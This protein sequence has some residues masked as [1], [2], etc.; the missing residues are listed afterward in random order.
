MTYWISYKSSGR[1]T[2]WNVVTQLTCGSLYGIRII[3]P[4]TKSSRWL[5]HITLCHPDGIRWFHTPMVSDK[6]QCIEDSFCMSDVNSSAVGWFPTLHWAPVTLVRSHHRRG[7]GTCTA[8]IGNGLWQ[9]SMYLAWFY[10][11]DANSRV[12]VDF[13]HHT[14]PQWPWYE[15]TI[16]EAG[17]LVQSL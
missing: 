3:P 15:A 14:E 7:W 5:T 13:K 2:A 9:K 10:F 11:S 12:G 16:V 8:I 4:S 17:D 1:D 6:N